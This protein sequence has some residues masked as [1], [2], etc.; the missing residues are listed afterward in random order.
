MKREEREEVE[1]EGMKS[2]VCLL[3]KFALFLEP[4]LIFVSLNS[5]P[6]RIVLHSSTRVPKFIASS[7]Y[8]VYLTLWQLTSR[9]EDLRMISKGIQLRRLLKPNAVSSAS[10]LPGSSLWLRGSF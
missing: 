7:F 4:L 9:T 1:I 5:D 2:E 3:S 8:G 10:D 6:C